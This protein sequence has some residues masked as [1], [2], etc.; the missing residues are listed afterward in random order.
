MGDIYAELEATHR[1][2]RCHMLLSHPDESGVLLPRLLDLSARLGSGHGHHAA[3]G[4]HLNR[5]EWREAEDHYDQMPGFGNYYLCLAACDRGLG[6]E[7]DERFQWM[8]Q[9]P[10]LREAESIDMFANYWA[11]LVAEFSRVTGDTRHFEEARTLAERVAD[12]EVA[13]RRSRVEALMGLGLLAVCRGDGPAAAE[14]YQRLTALGPR[15][16]SGTSWYY[17][18][19]AQAGALRDEAEHEYTA[20][21]DG[22][23]AEMH[24]WRRANVCCDFGGFLLERGTPQDL[25]RAAKLLSEGHD[26]G[27]RIGLATVVGRIEARLA[28]LEQ[29]ETP[30]PEPTALPDGLTAREVEILAQVA[31]GFNNRDIATQL[32][33]SAKTVATHLRNVYRKAGVANRAEATAYAISRGL[34]STAEDGSRV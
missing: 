34:I 19:I 13:T 32:F 29:L 23:T 4:W 26:L 21:L 25:L 6:D 8:V 11:T 18:R 27:E 22:T 9:R 28:R 33:I 10:Q 12:S 2:F 7:A 3:A 15:R 5:G 24:T 16:D 20:A 30:T 17:G 31:K 14:Y 1:L